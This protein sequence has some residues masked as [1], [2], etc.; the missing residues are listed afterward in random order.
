M[1]LAVSEE[2][3]CLLYSE[4]TSLPRL[5]GNWSLTRAAE[6]EMGKSLD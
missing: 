2:T 3:F 5:S 4:V 1:Y 6:G